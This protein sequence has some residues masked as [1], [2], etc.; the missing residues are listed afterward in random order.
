[1]IFMQDKPI[2]IVMLTHNDRTVSNAAEIFEECKNSRAQYWGFKEE[3]LCKAD[4]KNLFSYMKQCGKT[5]VLE[6]VAYTESEGLDGA[7]LAA[8]CGCDILMGTVYSDKI[9]KLCKEH[10]IKYM[11]FIGEVS[12]R[13]SILEGSCDDMINLANTLSQKGI[14]GIDLLSYRYT[15]DSHELNR[16]LLEKTDC[17]ICIAGSVDSYERFDEIKSLHAWGFTVGGALFENKFGGS[18]AEQINKICEYI[19]K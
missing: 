13:P 15:G 9:N 5:T 2:L 3:G 8:E 16:T 14:Y 11:P 1:M 19:E 7:R 12:E 6:V 10:N 4:M 17:P 18:I